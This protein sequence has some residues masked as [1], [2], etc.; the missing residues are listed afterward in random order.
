MMI[1]KNTLLGQLCDKC[2]LKQ[3]IKGCGKFKIVC[4]IIQ[5]TLSSIMITQKTNTVLKMDYFEKSY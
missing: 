5:L 3:H 1:F 4:Y 2:V